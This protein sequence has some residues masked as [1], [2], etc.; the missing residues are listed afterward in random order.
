MF[1]IN[2]TKH[3]RHPHSQKKVKIT[4]CPC[5]TFVYLCMCVFAKLLNNGRQTTCRSRLK[6]HTKSSN[7]PHR[8]ISHA[9]FEPSGHHKTQ[10]GRRHTTG[11]HQTMN[12][13]YIKNNTHD[14]RY[15]AVGWG[16]IVCTRR[17]ITDDIYTTHS[18]T[19]TK[20]TPIRVCAGSLDID[21]HYHVNGRQEGTITCPHTH[22]D[23]C[24]FTCCIH[25]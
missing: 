8:S 7:P 10:F 15:D 18:H 3:T 24:I 14:V 4:I 25:I 19:H 17:E 13:K 5:H 9:R 1:F 22:T 20:P 11:I 12:S 21:I 16:W 23:I 6:T 2:H